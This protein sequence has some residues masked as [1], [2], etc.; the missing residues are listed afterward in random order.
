VPI[1][2]A[3]GD[4]FL[5]TPANVT[6]YGYLPV[7]PMCIG[8]ALVMILV[9]LLTRPPSKAT[10]ERYFPGGGARKEIGGPVEMRR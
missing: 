5:R 8:S 2:P 4:L 10:L 6:V 7:M 1:F 9:S 3:L